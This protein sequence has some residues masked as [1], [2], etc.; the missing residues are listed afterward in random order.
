[1]F[2]DMEDQLKLSDR[3]VDI[4]DRPNR[5][6]CMTRYQKRKEVPYSEMSRDKDRKRKQSPYMELSR[7]N[8]QKRCV[9]R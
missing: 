3:V 2:K 6:I 4:V 1:M 8:D 9:Y 5:R 7:D